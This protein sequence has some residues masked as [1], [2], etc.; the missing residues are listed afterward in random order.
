MA[1]N[2]PRRAVALFSYVATYKDELSFRQGD[3]LNIQKSSSIEEGWFQAEKDGKTGIV[4]GNYLEFISDS[5]RTSGAAPDD[6]SR[7]APLLENEGKAPKVYR[8][9]GC[10]VAGPGC[11]IS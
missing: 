6:T 11:S 7:N 2:G 4:P 10:D 9:C 5:N 3:I 1:T 8:V